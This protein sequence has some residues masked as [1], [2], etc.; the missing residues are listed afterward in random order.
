MNERITVKVAAKRQEAADIVSFKLVDPTGQPLPP[1]TAGSHVDVEIKPDL[2]RQY[3]LC[4]V[5]NDTSA[6]SFYEIAVLQDPASRGG[7]LAMHE[8]VEGAL[9][10]ISPPRNQFPLAVDA[11]RSL[12]FAGGIGIT[13]LLCMAEQLSLLHADFR[14]FYCARSKTRMAFVDRIQHAAFASQVSLHLDDGAFAQKLVP[15]RELSSVDRDTHVYVCGPTGF[16]NWILNTARTAGWPESQLH[17]EYFSNA[18]AQASN[19]SPSFEVQVGVN[20]PVL[21]VEPEQSIANVLRA[22]GVYIPT[23]C[24]QGI[25]G[26]CLTNVLEGIPEH[27][28]QFLTEGERAANTMIMPCCS[29]AKSSRLVLD[30]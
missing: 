24:E 9:I 13:P 18:L 3:S 16:M 1:F 19:E 10:N 20:G 29:R 17:V 26:T 5:P 28:D 12:L 25:C 15:E 7:S 6:N 23:S 27:R 30:L 22:N 2:I 4:N 21:T 8:L 11:K 14:L